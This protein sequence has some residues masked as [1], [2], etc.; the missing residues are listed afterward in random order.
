MTNNADKQYLDLAKRII[1]TGNKK[2][3]RTGVGTLSIFGAQMRFD[4]NEGFPIL[5]TK[6][7]HFPSVVKELLW[8]I[9]GDTNNKTLQDQGVRIW[10][11]WANEFGDLGPVYSAM[12]RCWPTR[13]D[14]DVVELIKIKEDKHRDFLEP[15]PIFHPP[16]DCDL[17]TD[18]MWAIS[19]E[20]GHKNAVYT[21]QCASGYV[22]K[23]SRS[24]WKMTKDLKNLDLHYR[25]VEGVGFLGAKFLY[26][27]FVYDLWYNMIA[28]CYRKSH[29][30]YKFYGARGITVSP[31][32]HSFERFVKTISLVP[33]YSM[34]KQSPGDYQLDKDYYGSR[35]YSPSTCV[36]IPS[37]LNNS[38]RSAN[39][40]KIKGKIYKDYDHFYK[41]TGQRTDYM[42]ERLKAGKTYKD[43]KPEDVE[44]LKPPHGFVYRRR[45][46]VDQISKVIEDIKTNPNSRRL[47]VSAWNPEFVEKQKL[48]PCHTVFQFYVHD[49]KLSCH[50]FQRSGDFFLGIPFNIASYSLLTHMIAQVCG[51]G[52]GE[53]I[54]TIS[55]AHVYSNHLEAFQ[56]QMSREPFA[57]PKLVLNPNVTSLFDFKYEDISLEGYEHHPAI[58]AIV[59]V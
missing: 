39:A 47:I 17:N 21:Y 37:R 34:W 20:T 51:L 55:D 56:E 52:V 2:E 7:V 13:D 50:L 3:D 11:E 19:K 1:E 25:S 48:P 18:E 5:T 4:L 30:M 27:K 15:S 9:S 35:V 49:G 40:I 24:T 41:L 42:L 53:F 29:P 36:F 58:K 44:V 57:L 6:K 22:G 59:A 28:R 33:M 23:T 26:E 16:I 10:N 31:I 12:W 46:F 54:H 38:C 32:W 43:F 8:F 45:F 14:D